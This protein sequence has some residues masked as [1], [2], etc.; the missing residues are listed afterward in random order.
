MI[1][2]FR[3]ICSSKAGGNCLLLVR[4]K[5][6]EKICCNLVLRR[7]TFLFPQVRN[8]LAIRLFCEPT[9]TYEECCEQGICTKCKHRPKVEGYCH[10]KECR[11]YVELFNR[12]KYP[13]T[14]PKRVG[15]RFPLRKYKIDEQDLLLL[16]CTKCRRYLPEIDFPKQKDCRFERKTRCKDCEFNWKRVKPRKQ[17]KRNW[18][19]KDY[20]RR[21]NHRFFVKQ[22][23]AA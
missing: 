1:R 2:W 17:S 7:E 13:Y 15:K 4:G 3:C 22:P 23:L 16:E 20:M 5:N 9:M 18:F 19:G 14:N 6:T 8:G 11:D 12:R 21:T 10:C